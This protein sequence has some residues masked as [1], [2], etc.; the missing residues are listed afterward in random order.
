MNRERQSALPSRVAYTAFLVLVTA[1]ALAHGEEILVFPISFVL[2][3]VPATVIATVPWHRLRVRLSVAGLL[4]ATNV[5]LWFVPAIPQTV[6]ALAAYDLRQAM[7]ILLFAP[8][9]LATI[10][11][12]L[13]RKFI[14]R[15]GRLTRRWSGL[16][17]SA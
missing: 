15:R 14:A 7:A 8:V 12:G 17:P 5:T 11:G 9:A 4:L 6:G 3:I 13:C 2:L 1:P 10:V 16:P